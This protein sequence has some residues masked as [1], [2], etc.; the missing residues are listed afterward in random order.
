MK[1]IVT[2][3]NGLVG[4]GVLLEALDQED[5]QE[6]L[7]IARRKTGL[8]HPK[9]KE[10]IHADFSEFKS[11]EDELKGYDACFA[12]MGVSAAGMNEEQY[13][14]LTFDYTIALAKTFKELNP[15]ACFTY[16]SGVVTDSSEKGRQM[17]ARVK[18]KTENELL[19]LGFKSASMF[20]PGMIIPMRGVKS[21]TKLYQFMYDYFMW[22]VHLMKRLSPSSVVNTDQIGQ[23]MLEVARGKDAPKIL[24]SKDILAHAKA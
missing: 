23:A 7:S 21:S 19:A 15:N 14:K 8:S 17:W 16:V 24:H 1:I 5:V 2:G 12:C 6:V 11:V 20:R 22:L 18:G 3:A 4:K 13:S 9:L 10:L